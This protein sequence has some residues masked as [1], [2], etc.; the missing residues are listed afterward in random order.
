MIRHEGSGLA[1]EL[2]VTPAVPWHAGAL[3][4]GWV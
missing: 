4:L 1:A 2:E 3:L